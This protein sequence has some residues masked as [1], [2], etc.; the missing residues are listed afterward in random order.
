M[1]RDENVFLVGPMG[2]GKSTIGRALAS[3]LGKRFMDCDHEIEGRTGASIPLIFEIEGETG[4]R[5]RESQVLDEL[6]QDGGI[7][8]AT[9]GGAVLAEENRQ[10]L[11]SR[12]IVIYLQAPIEVLVKRTAHDRNRPLLANVDRREKLTELMQVREPLYREVADIVVSSGG[13]PA[14]AV[15]RDIVK[16]LK[17][18][19]GD[20]RTES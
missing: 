13:R 3:Q 7:V 11:K 6:T 15:A 18:L 8:L 19:S 9:G 17:D 5:K 2:S 1:K 20:A 16:Q 12:G 10:R 4:F 14:S